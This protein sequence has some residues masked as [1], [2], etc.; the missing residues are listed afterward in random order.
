[1]PDPLPDLSRRVPQPGTPLLDVIEFY[2]RTAPEMLGRENYD[3]PIVPLIGKNPGVNGGRWYDCATSDPEAAKDHLTLLGKMGGGRVD[4][5]GSLMDDYITFDV[6]HPESMPRDLGAIIAGGL[7]SVTRPGRQHRIFRVPRGRRFGGRKDL[8]NGAFPCASS[9]GEIKGFHS[10]V[11]IWS[12]NHDD[13]THVRLIPGVVPMLPAELVPLL[14]EP[15]LLSG[16]PVSVAVL[17]EWL[18]DKGPLAEGGGGEV[19]LHPEWLEADVRKL[20]QIDPAAPDNSKNRRVLIRVWHVAINAAAGCYPARRAYDRL[21]DE[22]VQVCVEE[23]DWQPGNDRK[24]QDIWRRVLGK[25][26]TDPG[27]ADRVERRKI[28][29]RTAGGGA[30]W[31]P[32]GDDAE[33]VGIILGMAERAGVTLTPAEMALITTGE[34]VVETTARELRELME[35]EEHPVEGAERAAAVAESVAHHPSGGASGGAEPPK[36]IVG[37]LGAPETPPEV[38]EGPQEGPGGVVV[39]LFPDGVAARVAGRLSAAERR[40]AVPNPMAPSAGAVSGVSTPWAPG[41]GEAPG[42]VSDASSAVPPIPEI[43]SGASSS[44]TPAPFDGE[45]EISS[46]DRLELDP[47]LEEAIDEAAALEAEVL[48]ALDEIADE[49]DEVGDSSSEPGGTAEAGD[50]DE[51]TSSAGTAGTSAGTAG[52]AGTA[53]AGAGDADGETVWDRQKRKAKADVATMGPLL[54]KLINDAAARELVR[55]LKGHGEVV[56]EPLTFV[57]LVTPPPPEMM[58]LSGRADGLGL[59]YGDAITSLFGDKQAGKSWLMLYEALRQVRAGRTVG[60]LDWEM[61]RP[62]FLGRLLSLGACEADLAGFVYLP[63]SK[64]SF[65]DARLALVRLP[66][67]SLIVIDSVVRALVNEGE[68]AD[69]NSAMAYLRFFEQLAALRKARGCPVVAIDHVGHGARHRSRGT[70][71]KGQALDAEMQM[72]VVEKWSRTSAGWA[73]L[74]VRKDRDGYLEQDEPAYGAFFTPERLL[75][76]GGW[77]PAESDDESVVVGSGGGWAG[78]VDDDGAVRLDVDVR[79]LREWERTEAEIA[80]SDEEDEGRAKRTEKKTAARDAEVAAAEAAILAVLADR[81]VHSERDLETRT[82]TKRHIVREAV[83]KLIARGEIERTGKGGKG[84]GV[85]LP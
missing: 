3:L 50:E 10:Q 14:M 22:Y 79:E 63:M 30:P 54:K 47:E 15:E 83:G 60:W 12:P 82:G 61:S 25:I 40:S 78:S 33:L 48:E 46:E 56:A 34:P 69:E 41:G 65:E 32:L 2:C 71:S 23:G 58:P 19:G 73:A 55:E 74:I 17:D 8:I 31:D 18:D 1:M 72:V 28:E 45:L 27:A 70:S 85:S 52:T 62:R 53:G 24:Y 66:K 57:G 44:G 16:D 5:F 9:W 26:E 51:P 37:S 42:S 67:G 39:P 80:M 35:A 49:P 43:P 20:R 59:I 13:G 75:K 36:P 11:R 4:G 76:S 29:V 38:A 77:A 64:S 68:D 84:S 81:M 21:Y 6:D 7:G